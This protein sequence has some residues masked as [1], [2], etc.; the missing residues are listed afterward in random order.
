MLKNRC[1]QLFYVADSLFNSN[2]K[3]QNHEVKTQVHIFPSCPAFSSFAFSSFMAVHL[4]C[5]HIIYWY[6][7]FPKLLKSGLGS[8]LL[9]NF[10]EST[11]KRIRSFRKFYLYCFIPQ[12]Q[13]CIQLSYPLLVKELQQRY[14]INNFKA[15]E[16][17]LP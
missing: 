6:R 2:Y 13:H 5:M 1:K 7:I 9:L 14:P 8:Q 16:T 17:S 4:Q 12:E 3:H 10:N 15:S 11:H